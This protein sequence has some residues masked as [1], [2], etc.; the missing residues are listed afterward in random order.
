VKRGGSGDAKRVGNRD[1][2]RVGNRDTK[3][4]GSGDVKKGRRMAYAE[5]CKHFA[6]RWRLSWMHRSWLDYRPWMPKLSRAF[7]RR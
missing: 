6:G 5:V 3:R 2:K 4:V 1:V 7:P